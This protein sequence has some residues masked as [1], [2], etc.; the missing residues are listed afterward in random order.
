MDFP[1]TPLDTKRTREV[2]RWFRNGK[3]CYRGESSSCRPSD[4]GD[5]GVGTY[6]TTEKARA[7]CYGKV[8]T[9]VVTLKNPLVL[10]DHV[11]Y[12][13]IAERYM[14]CR[15]DWDR[16]KA[17]AVA[18]TRMLRCLGFD[19]LVSVSLSRQEI[20]VVVFSPELTPSQV[21]DQADSYL[22]RRADQRLLECGA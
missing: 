4:P 2:R 15:G 7:R 21:D 22:E 8:G 12:E 14:T 5:L 17:G 10:S 19:G 9:W 13:V 3:V 16:R 18:A 1:I 11:A 20:E 6:F